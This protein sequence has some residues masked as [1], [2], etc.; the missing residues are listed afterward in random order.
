[1]SG[2]DCHAQF[3]FRV[4]QMRQ[5]VNGVQVGRVGNGD[6]DLALGFEDGNDAV[7]F[8]DVARNDGDD[9]VGNLHSGQLH[10]FRA[11]LRGLGLRSRPPAG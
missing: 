1:M 2:S 3:D 6:G 7:F 5:R 8:G 4:E 9:V 11:E 10:H